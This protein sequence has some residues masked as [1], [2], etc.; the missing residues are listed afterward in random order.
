M[1]ITER[2]RS[3]IAKAADDCGSVNAFAQR[4]GIRHTTVRA[5]IRG[6]AKKTTREN[7]GRLLYFLKPYLDEGE[8]HKHVVD[9]NRAGVLA[10]AEASFKRNAP[11]VA[12]VIPVDPSRGDFYPVISDAAAANVDTLYY[13]MADFAIA[14]AETRQFFAS[15]RP[16]DFAIRVSGDSMLPWYP[17]G[18]LLLV[19]PNARLQ[20]GDRVVAIFENGDIVF[21]VF[22]QKGGKVGLLSINHDGGNDYV[23]DAEDTS[24][25][26]GMYKVIASARDEEKLDHAMSDSGIR[27]DWQ[28]KIKGW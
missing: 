21:K 6:L 7:W 1:E 12:E 2:L 25:I 9:Y 27:H 3:L 23:F 5:W 20:S 24:K 18:T 15:G 4:L 10:V 11:S 28:D 26:R 14:E 17:T 8:Y 22:V 19:R 16:G 13:P